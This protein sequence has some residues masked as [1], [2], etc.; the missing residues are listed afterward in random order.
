MVLRVQELHTATHCNSATTLQ[1]HYNKT[2]EM[3]IKL[4]F[5]NSQHGLASGTATHYNTTTTL[6]QRFN[7]TLQ[8]HCNTT[9]KPSIDL[10]VVNFATHQ[11]NSFQIMRWHS[12]CGNVVWI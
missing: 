8:Q 3:P 9:F 4:T 7:A 10:T 5:E 6:Q 12:R 11:H 2:V 1:Q